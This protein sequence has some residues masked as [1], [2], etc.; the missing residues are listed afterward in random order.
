MSLVTVTVTVAMH[1]QQGHS[2][3]VVTGSVLLRDAA[4]P[5]VHP[6]K[7]PSMAIIVIKI[8]NVIVAVTSMYEK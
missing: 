6:G 7:R 2:L 8:S 5:R 3:L 4:Q 1:C